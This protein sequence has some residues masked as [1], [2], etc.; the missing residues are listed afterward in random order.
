MATASLCELWASSPTRSAARNAVECY[1]DPARVDITRAWCVLKLHVMLDKNNP[2]I[3]LTV[4]G[5][6]VDVQMKAIY[7]ALY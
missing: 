3:K 1:G 2:Y 6:S 4:Y 5:F 7:S